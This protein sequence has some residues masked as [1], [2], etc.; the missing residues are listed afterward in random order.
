MTVRDGAWFEFEALENAPPEEAGNE[1]LLLVDGDPSTYWQSNQAGVKTIDMR[2]RT[3]NKRV[4]MF[5]FRTPNITDVRSQWQDFTIRGAQSIAKLDDADNIL[6]TGVDLV[7]PGAGSWIEYTLPSIKK[8]R[9][10]RFEVATSLHRNPD[11]IRMRQI[12]ARVVI[13]NHDN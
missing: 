11:Q 8:L 4:S 1:A 5:R 13:T 9:Y 6:A 3:Y 7:H 12:E 10:V 2:L